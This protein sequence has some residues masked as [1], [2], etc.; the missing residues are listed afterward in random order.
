MIEGAR[1]RTAHARNQ[2]GQA[3][4]RSNQLGA[5]F[6]S[7][8][9]YSSTYV[10]IIENTIFIGTLLNVL[11]NRTLYSHG[12]GSIQTTVLIRNNLSQ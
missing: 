4:H 5:N 7:D 8:Y 6:S 3:L 12:S 10:L 2:R 11:E 9:S 1:E